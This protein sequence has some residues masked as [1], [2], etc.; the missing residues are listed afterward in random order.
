MCIRDRANTLNWR[1]CEFWK[2]MGAVRVNLARELTLSEIAE[3]SAALR[4]RDCRLE[5][6]AFVHGAMCLSYSGRCMLSDSLA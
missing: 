6:E 3:I 4:E 5:L 2:K 1:T